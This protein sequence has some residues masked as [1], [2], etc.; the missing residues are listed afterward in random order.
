MRNHPLFTFLSRVGI[1]FILPLLPE[2]P[3]SARNLAVTHVLCSGDHVQTPK[4]LREAPL[5]SSDP[6]G[7]VQC[8]RGSFRLDPREK[9]VLRAEEEVLDRV[10]KR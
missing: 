1:H 7:K 4:R 2:E 10:C 6:R 8:Y 9:A 3:S 5:V